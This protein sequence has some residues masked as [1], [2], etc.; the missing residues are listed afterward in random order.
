MPD[1]NHFEQLDAKHAQ[2]DRERLEGVLHWVE[3]IR[4]EPPEVWGDQQN[5][6]V[7]AQLQSAQEAGLT[8][9]HKQRVR[10]FAKGVS[11]TDPEETDQ[12]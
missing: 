11:E 10:E 2:N 4:E 7:N 12:S 5:Q 3:Y 6:L 9:E 1:S 8:A